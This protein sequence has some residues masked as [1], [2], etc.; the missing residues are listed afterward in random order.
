VA[1]PEEEGWLA[2]A[3]SGDRQAFA[4]LVRLHGP[5][6][7]GWL[8]RLSGDYQKAEDILQETFFKG[9]RALPQYQKGDLRA[10]LFRIAYRAWLDRRPKG[11]AVVS[12]AETP[13][14]AG[15]DDPQRSAQENEIER[16]IHEEWK[17]LPELYRVALD[18]HVREGLEYPELAAAL[19]VT[20]STARWRVFKARRLLLKRL[21]KFLDRKD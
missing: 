11:S 13:D 6:L 3:Q 7:F 16:S 14:V 17:Q 9:W 2:K 15:R 10:W 8:M 20:E 18:L 19:S 21:G 12:L 5:H 4:E 1:S